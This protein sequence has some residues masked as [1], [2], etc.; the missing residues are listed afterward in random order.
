MTVQIMDEILG[1]NALINPKNG[2]RLK[3]AS[4]VLDEVFTI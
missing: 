1:T 4:P 2:K 3:I